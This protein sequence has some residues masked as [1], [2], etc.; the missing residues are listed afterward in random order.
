M[1]KLKYQTF[2]DLKRYH[3]NI[4]RDNSTTIAYRRTQRNDYIVAGKAQNVHELRNKLFP[5][6]NQRYPPDH[7]D[8]AIHPQVNDR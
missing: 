6:T 4:L 5:K 7:T 8:S 2:H 1:Q 3:L